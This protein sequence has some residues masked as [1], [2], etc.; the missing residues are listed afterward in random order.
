LR[1][2]GFSADR[3]TAAGGDA[4]KHLRPLKR[5]DIGAVE[6]HWNVTA[7]G[8]GISIDPAPLWARAEPRTF[9][10]VTALGL[11]PSDLVLHLT[12]HASYD[13]QFGQGVRPMIDLAA[14]VDRYHDRIEWRAVLARAREWGWWHGVG[15]ALSL[16]ADWA[17]ADIPRDVLAEI[18]IQKEEPIYGVAEQQIA[19][20]GHVPLMRHTLTALAHERR[21]RRARYGLA[22]L[23]PALTPTAREYGTSTRS[24]TFWSFYV[25]DVAARVVRHTP[26]LARWQFRGDADLDAFALNQNRLS[27]WMN[28]SDANEGAHG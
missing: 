2:L 17:E 3:P 24:F 26:T 11:A 8:R 19:G 27:K 18:G 5:A 10:A 9:S 22:R 21:G 6:L 14:V 20:A 23:F 1:A 4:A 12:A 28:D 25:R 13:H 15:L 16:A 7:D